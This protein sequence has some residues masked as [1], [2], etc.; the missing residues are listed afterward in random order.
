MANFNKQSIAI[1][2]MVDK[3]R[4][5]QE[6]MKF[7]FYTIDD[8]EGAQLLMQNTAKRGFFKARFLNPDALALRNA[9]FNKGKA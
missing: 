2:E 6:A 8:S 3:A 7:A 9:I 1:K 5:Q 4:E